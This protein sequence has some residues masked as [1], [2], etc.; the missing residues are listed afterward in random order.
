MSLGFVSSPFSTVSASG[1][2]S[3]ALRGEKTQMGRLR[4]R[5]R[6][7]R[8]YELAF[9][10]QSRDDRFVGWKLV[11]GEIVRPGDGKSMGHAW[12][13][14]AGKIYDPVF[15]KTYEIESYMTKFQAKAIASYSQSEAIE[16]AMKFERPHFGPWHGAPGQRA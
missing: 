8:C 6:Q 10:F 12:L 4:P 7:G 9:K 16:T 1:S 15:D 14:S 2:V 13:E 5:Y 11:H 3:G